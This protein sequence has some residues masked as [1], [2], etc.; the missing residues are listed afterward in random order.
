[1]SA[2]ARPVLPGPSCAERQKSFEKWHFEHPERG[3]CQKFWSLSPHPPASKNTST[4]RTASYDSSQV[5][6]RQETNDA[7]LCTPL[8]PAGSLS[9]TVRFSP[10]LLQA[11]HRARRSFLRRPLPNAPGLPASPSTSLTWPLRSTGSFLHLPCP[12]SQEPSVQLN[13]PTL[14]PCRAVLL[15]KSPRSLAGIMRCRC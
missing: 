3:G 12:S 15:A 14:P 4:S 10:G 8:L 6:F 7:H 11:H 5:L 1:M 2:P 13:K 9:T